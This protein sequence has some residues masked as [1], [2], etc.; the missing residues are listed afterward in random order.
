MK[1]INFPSFFHIG[2]NGIVEL[3]IKN[4]ADLNI[5]DKVNKTA[6]QK[7]TESSNFWIFY[8]LKSRSNFENNKILIGF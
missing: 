4:G 3:L 5:K 1:V 6:I 8:K 2:R 7:A